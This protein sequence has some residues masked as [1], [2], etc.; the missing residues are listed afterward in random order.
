MPSVASTRGSM[1]RADGSE[2]DE[3][4]QLSMELGADKDI[5]ASWLADRVATAGGAVAKHAEAI[6]VVLYAYGVDTI[7]SCANLSREEIIEAIQ[8]SADGSQSKEAGG[9]PVMTKINAK[10]VLGAIR[11]ASEVQYA[12]VAL[13]LDSFVGSSTVVLLTNESTRRCRCNV[14]IVAPRRVVV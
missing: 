2:E 1:E 11:R 14:R 5:E 13:G 10:K 8:D 9:L 4:V 12:M 7:W 6:A 3:E